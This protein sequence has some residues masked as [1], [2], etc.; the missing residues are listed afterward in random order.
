[1]SVTL[2]VFTDDG[3][4]KDVPIAD[5][6]H[7]IGRSDTATI[8]V[9]KPSVSRAHCELTIDGSTVA[10][11]DLGSSNGTFKNFSRVSE[12]QLGPGDVL[13]VGDIHLTIQINGKPA[14]ISKPEPPIDDASAESSM[15]DTPPAGLGGGSASRASG[16]SGGASGSSPSQPAGQ[17][18]KPAGSSRSDSTD[19]DF[20]FDLDDSDAPKL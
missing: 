13:G 1:V 8:R 16:G 5:G 19:F 18:G 10:V 17:P 12:A 4:R 3:R 15:M 2:V 14:S 20:D 6:V 11:R 7:I 9:P